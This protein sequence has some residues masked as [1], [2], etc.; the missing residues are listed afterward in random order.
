MPRVHYYTIFFF[1]FIL[2]STTP[3]AAHPLAG[4][5]E[6]LPEAVC[7][8]SASF[9]LVGRRS[10]MLRP[11]TA[12]QLTPWRREPWND[13]NLPRPSSLPFAYSA[14]D[15]FLEIWSA[16]K[17]TPG[18][19]ASPPAADALPPNV[20]LPDPSPRRVPPDPRVISGATLLDE[21]VG[22]FSLRPEFRNPYPDFNRRS[23]GD[24]DVLVVYQSML[25]DWIQGG[26]WR[27]RPE[28]SVP[29]LPSEAWPSQPNW[30][31]P[32]ANRRH[33][34]HDPDRQSPSTVPEPSDRAFNDSLG[35]VRGVP[36]NVV[37][38]YEYR[39]RRPEIAEWPLDPMFRRNEA[40]P[41]VR[42]DL[43]G[44]GTD[45]Q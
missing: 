22:G 28:L 32:S 5:F 33:R 29:A 23:D 24:V 35:L 42:R 14:W 12:A 6:L 10:H 25:R 30:D 45:D 26:S 39:A 41:M 3:V 31:D 15:R 44:D 36:P 7:S 17:N 13:R 27:E 37:P 18:L 16:P 38:L 40:P 19:L 43:R 20:H 1:S 21:L 34:L 8:E 11:H 4:S 9:I 2:A